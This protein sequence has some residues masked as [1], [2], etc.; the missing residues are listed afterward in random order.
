MKVI[1]LYCGLGGW[2]RGL[3]DTGHDV[4][5]YDIIDFS[6]SY[7]GKFIKADLLTYNDFPHAD[8]IVASPPC[9][10]FSKA[11]FPPT[12]TAVKLYPP[13]IPSAMELFNRVY[14]IV[15]L[16]SAKYYIIENVVGAQKYMGKARMH[17]GSRYFWG[18]FPAF[19]NRVSS[20]NGVFDGMDIRYLTPLECERLMGWE[21]NWT[22]YGINEKGETI[23]LSDNCRY[24]LIGNGVVP[25]VVREIISKE[26]ME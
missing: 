12:W 14:E 24:N 23:E 17:I 21:D 9:T 25:Q 11:S 18:N 5:G 22:K 16:T 8:V 10:D 4:T 15:A 2:A 3:K 13:N 19:T 20:R 7:P 26:V 1:D 6:E